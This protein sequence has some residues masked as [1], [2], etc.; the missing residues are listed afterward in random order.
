MRW[1]LST[2][3]PVYLGELSHERQLVSSAN[4]RWATI[5]LTTAFIRLCVF[6]IIIQLQ[7]HNQRMA[8]VAPQMQAL[9]TG[10]QAAQK[11][12]DQASMQLHKEALQ[13]L[14]AKHDVNPFRMMKVPAVQMPIFISMFYGLRRLAET[15]LP[16]FLEGGLGWV[17]DL[18]L[19]DPYY[20]L[21]ITSIVFTNIVIRV[22]RLAPSSYEEVMADMSRWAQMG[23]ERPHRLMSSLD[24]SRI[25]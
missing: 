4:P 22:S 14:M 9:S 11:A 8:A 13:N 24:I 25:S 10:L 17:T 6:R 12:G 19:A 20:I 15:P 18:T 21:P 2:R 3:S 16:G 7:S 23:L 5:A 1:S